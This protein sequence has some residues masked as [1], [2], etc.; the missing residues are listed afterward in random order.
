[1][2]FSYFLKTLPKISANSL[3][4]SLDDLIQRHLVKREIIVSKPPEI[5][6]SQTE[7]GKIITE[8]AAP[9]FLYVGIV[10]G[11]YRDVSLKLKSMTV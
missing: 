7:E 9:L 4:S 3:S 11:Y 5:E 8:I 1:M 10:G 6:Y 2:K